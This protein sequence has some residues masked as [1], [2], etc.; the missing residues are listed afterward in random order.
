MKISDK[1]HLWLFTSGKGAPPKRAFC[2]PTAGM[3]VVAKR[4]IS[5]P[6]AKGILVVQ[7]LASHYTD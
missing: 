7:P 5:A 2:W 4:K 3:D 6:A 1:C